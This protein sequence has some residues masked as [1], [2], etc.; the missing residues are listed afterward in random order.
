MLEYILQVGPG[1]VEVSAAG[2]F[3][4]FFFATFVSEDAACIIAGTAVASGR[5]GFAAA[6]TACFLGIFAGDLLL[7]GF[8]RLAGTRILEN[9]I[10]RK[11]VT[12]AAI[13][14]ASKWLEENAAAAVF[15]SRFVTGLRL[16][17][18]LAAG[19]FRTE[20]LKFAFWFLVASAVWTPILVGSAAFAQAAIFS[21]YSLFGVI[22]LI[23][24]AR[25]GSNFTSWKNRRLFVGKLKRIRYWE[26]WP[27]QIFYLPVVLY[28][29]WLGVRYRSLTAFTAANPGLPAGGF[30]GE[31]KEE[32]YQ[33][34]KRSDGIGKHLLAH[35]LIKLND[36]LRQR[37]RSA[38]H[39]MDENLLSFPLAIKPDAGE[40][41]NGV[42][43]L[44]SLDELANALA[45]AER[46][47]ILQEYAPGEEVSVFY[48]RYPKHRIGR[49]FSITEKQFPEVIGNGVSTI[50]ELILADRRAVAMAKKYFESNKER[51]GCIPPKGESI[52]LIDIGTH[53][54][55]AV[56]L[57]G[58]WMRT[59]AL[60]AKIDEIC[61]SFEG[62]YFGRF[63]IRVPAH[64][65]MQKGENFKII[66]LNGVT[67][68]STNIYD[69]RYS[70]FDAYRIL[71]HQWRLAFA[72]GA[73]N[74]E[75]GA[76]PASLYELARSA[77]GGDFR[78]PG[79]SAVERET[80]ECA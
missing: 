69:P 56:F 80:V 32:I 78:S 64:S 16:P 9:R 55:G 33:A 75:L 20:F 37:L 44:R 50:E 34:L 51:L 12:Q 48:Y 31:S 66:E 8:G 39:F 47:M 11:L 28:V 36:P 70:L 38:W 5:I 21:Q 63:D 77:I 57:D 74:I 23:V 40:R 25:I 17:T 6:L 18:Y 3:A 72:I 10:V 68:E 53:S 62:F 22:A 45:S 79:R 59:D 1:L 58:G 13:D 43:I 60:E 4:F 54:R 71:F 49:I 76:K 19:A 7:F 35:K 29:L 30:K 15:I 67:S 42:R 65:E 41:G 73:E 26:F 46:D 14:R 24:A 27:I 61:R 52:R 2:L